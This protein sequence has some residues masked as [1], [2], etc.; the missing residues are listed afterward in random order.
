MSS[1]TI[2][3]CKSVV[4]LA[5]N[6]HSEATSELL[7]GE[8]V[9]IL[10]KGSQWCKVRSERDGYEGYVETNCCDVN[11][12]AST[13]WVS[14]KATPVFEKPNIK[15]RVL[16]RLLFGSELTATEAGTD[17]EFLSLHG[18][19]YIWAL[20][21]SKINVPLAA[22]MIDIAQN[23]Y[24]N[25]PYVWGGRST[26]GCDC[27]GLLQMVARA[28]GVDLPRD[29]VDQEAAFCTDI[30]YESR[31]TE[32]VVFWPGHVGLLKTPELIL[33]STAHFMRCCIEPLQYVVDR[34]GAPSS[35]KRIQNNRVR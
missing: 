8:S 32:D 6:I 35:I 28:T 7:F 11:G 34:A 17:S 27:S 21:C 30:E 20:H 9:L 23:N 10:E 25:A 26:D 16:K 22:G 1:A 24:L 3:S 13:H 5:P 15:S 12:P 29:S 2:N 33:H 4:K 14:T 19:G 18:G 31:A